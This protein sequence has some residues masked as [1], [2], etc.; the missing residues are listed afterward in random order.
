MGWMLQDEPLRHETPASY[1]TRHFTYDSERRRATVLATATTYVFAAVFLFK[2]NRSAGFGYKDMT[3]SM[4]PHECDCPDRIMQLLSPV[5]D[6]PDPSYSADW[7]A[8]VAA[9]KAQRKQARK[10]VDAVAIGDVV[11][12]GSEVAFR[13]GVRAQAFRMIDQRKRT[14]IFEPLSH[15][16]MRCRLPSQMIAT[17]TVERARAADQT[18]TP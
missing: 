13:G 5:E 10:S 12:L 4:G 16:G 8:R 15:P 2:N 17:A 6:I 14:R 9:R 7:R 18:A 3:E 1:I 11:R